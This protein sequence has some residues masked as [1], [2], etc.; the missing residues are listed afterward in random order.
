MHVRSHSVGLYFQL[1]PTSSTNPSSSFPLSELTDATYS[2]NLLPLET[3]VKQTASLSPVSSKIE[4]KIAG[5]G[6]FVDVK[7][8]DSNE[9]MDKTSTL[10]DS[11]PRENKIEKSDETRE[12]VTLEG[13]KSLQN[14]IEN[15]EEIIN[16]MEGE[17]NVSDG[18]FNSLMLSTPLLA[19]DMGLKG[20]FGSFD[21][22][23][24]S[25]PL[26]RSNLESVLF[27]SKLQS[28][29]L[30]NTNEE[31]SSSNISI[32]SE[33]RLDFSALRS[34]ASNIESGITR[35]EGV[36]SAEKS[37]NF[38]SVSSIFSNGNVF[39][40]TT[41]IIDN[42]M[43]NSSDAR[44]IAK[45]LEK[46]NDSLNESN[47]Y[48]NDNK[49]LSSSLYSVS[50]FSGNSINNSGNFKNSKFSNSNVKLNGSQKNYNIDYDLNNSE[51]DARNSSHGPTLSYS[52]STQTKLNEKTVEH[53]QSSIG[54]QTRSD[55]CTPISNFQFC[56]VA[57]Q[58][59]LSENNEK[60]SNSFFSEISSSNKTSIP[61]VD[62]NQI[63]DRF[64]RL[65]GQQIPVVG[66][67]PLKMFQM[68]NNQEI[69]IK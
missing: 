22:T 58:T 28:S 44:V 61:V 25:D 54:V 36:L 66:F 13:R 16:Q 39:K 12:S 27:E 40:S 7:K 31:S 4:T 29:D 56:N 18:V 46:L 47:L 37:N 14:N 41:P 30:G 2:P 3:L 24:F 32:L 63:K 8:E 49:R 20:T 69:N 15:K 68:K 1:L 67:I 42:K 21:N 19:S 10:R 53:F 52:V 35:L 26:G 55:N 23:K 59:K 48:S 50:E 57:T 17:S 62:M 34:V 43:L 64:I 33:S 5:N 38:S 11:N 60:Q 65:N 51:Y 6:E 9:I 45:T